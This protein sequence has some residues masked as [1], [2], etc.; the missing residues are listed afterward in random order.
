MSDGCNT[1]SGT[2]EGGRGDT[3]GPVASV[4]LVTSSPKLTRTRDGDLKEGAL[5]NEIDLRPPQEALDGGGSRDTCDPCFALGL[6]ASG[7][8]NSWGGAA[9]FESVLEGK[10]GTLEAS[11]DAFGRVADGE[12]S[13][14]IFD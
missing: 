3:E 7:S 12:V 9:G 4:G 10:W 14:C 1:G 5:K 8:G 13:D 2:Y 11:E 6:R